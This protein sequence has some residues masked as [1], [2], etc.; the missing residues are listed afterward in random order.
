MIL[1]RISGADWTCRVLPQTQHREWDR[2]LRKRCRSCRGVLRDEFC[3]GASHV[4]SSSLP[5]AGRA[6]VRLEP[7]TRVSYRLSANWTTKRANSCSLAI[8]SRAGGGRGTNGTIFFTRGFTSW[9]SRGLRNRRP[10]RGRNASTRIAAPRSGRAGWRGA[11]DRTR[12]TCP[13]RRRRAKRRWP[14][15]SK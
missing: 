7:A 3:D 11:R 12:R 9:G 8:V 4:Q 2:C 13:Q 15:G 10:V 1:E 14:R 5:L 6:G